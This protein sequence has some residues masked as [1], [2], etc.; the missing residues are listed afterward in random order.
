MPEAIFHCQT[1][2]RLPNTSHV[3]FPESRGSRCSSAS[4]SR[5]FAVSTGSACSSG[6]VE[7]SKTLLA[8]GLPPDEALA[9]LRISFGISNTPEEVD[10]FLDALDGEVAA[11]RR[12]S[13]LARAVA[14]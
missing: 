9:S 8:I 1:S 4:T 14:S 12:V 13:P 3:A 10:A 2:P 5:G 6:A 11:L 7:P